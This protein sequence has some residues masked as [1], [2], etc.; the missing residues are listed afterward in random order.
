MIGRISLKITQFQLI[1]VDACGWIYMLEWEQFYNFA[2]FLSFLKF[3]HR[4]TCYH[5]QLR[6]NEVNDSYSLN[7]FLLV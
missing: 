7:F 4:V 5:A 2:N 1:S 6:R 3:N